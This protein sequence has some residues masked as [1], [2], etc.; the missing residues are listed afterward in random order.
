MAIKCFPFVKIYIWIR[1]I[2]NSFSRLQHDFH[3]QPPAYNQIGRSWIK[4]KIIFTKREANSHQNLK[5]NTK[6]FQPQVRWENT[7]L[8]NILPWKLSDEGNTLWLPPYT[9]CSTFIFNKHI[10]SQSY[11]TRKSQWN[12]VN[13]PKRNKT[14]SVRVN[15]PFMNLLARVLKNHNVFFI[16]VNFKRGKLKSGRHPSSYHQ[17]FSC[18]V[19][20]IIGS[21]K[22]DCW[23]HVGCGAKPFKQGLIL[24]RLPLQYFGIQLSPRQV[25]G[26]TF[27]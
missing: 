23:G 7:R 26:C 3:T 25:S 13:L 6:R 21:Q 20:S 22:G 11:P 12:N 9:F 5:Q 14:K 8:H 1:L 18:Y 4:G 27:F 19:R 15:F 16:R 24:N 17:S 2:S 10:T